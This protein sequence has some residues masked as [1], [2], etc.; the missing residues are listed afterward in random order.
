[1]QLLEI[2][3]VFRRGNECEE[4]KGKE[5]GKPFYHA[6]SSSLNCIMQSL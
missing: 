3:G 6:C 2:V 4:Q 1:M 5:E